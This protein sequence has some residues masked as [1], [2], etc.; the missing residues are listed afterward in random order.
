MSCGFFL[1]AL[2]SQ[3]RLLNRYSGHAHYDNR[4]C[5]K[6]EL[7]SFLDFVSNVWNRRCEIK[8]VNKIVRNVSLF[9]LL[10]I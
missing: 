8:V 7:G 10:W 5:G 6:G 1:V 4:G 3:Y 9:R 2:N